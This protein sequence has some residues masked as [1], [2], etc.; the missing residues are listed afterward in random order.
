MTLSCFT[1][2][3]GTL[4]S[5]DRIRDGRIVKVAETLTGGLTFVEFTDGSSRC[6]SCVGVWRA[7]P[8]SKPAVGKD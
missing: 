4:R 1:G 7:R 2:W 5:G 3:P 8:L 6:Y